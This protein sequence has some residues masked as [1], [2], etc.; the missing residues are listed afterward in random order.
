M[1][2]RSRTLRAMAL[3]VMVFF[4]GTVFM[5]PQAEANVKHL[6]LG[7]GLGVVGGALF[8]PAIVGGLSAA[9]GLIGGAV[10]AVGGALAG[11]AGAVG[12]GI[13]AVA[14]SP[15]FIPAVCLGAGILVGKLIWDHSKQNAG[16]RTDESKP[17]L[18]SKVGS[19][20]KNLFNKAKGVVTG[21]GST[22]TTTGGG[23]TDVTYYDPTGGSVTTPDV[24]YAGPDRSVSRI[25][26]Q[27]KE[28]ISNSAEGDLKTQYEAA[29]QR[30]V[31]LLQSGKTITDSDV[32]AALANYKSLYKQY[33]DM[34]SAAK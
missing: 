17:S 4:L 6:L 32:Q 19:G 14:A 25:S 9:G 8:G 20:V 12:S 27:E 31:E 1:I 10:T 33:Q 13:L 21:K 28:L 5:A 23:R 30:Y 22:T 2:K 34:I 3:T 11:V 24:S 15:F 29:Y 18:I 26:G 7:A 16:V